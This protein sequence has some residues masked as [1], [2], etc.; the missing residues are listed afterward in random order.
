ML[1]KGYST[2]VCNCP[3]RELFNTRNNVYRTIPTFGILFEY[4]VGINSLISI[5]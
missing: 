5:K 4:D 3:K 1:V 2:T